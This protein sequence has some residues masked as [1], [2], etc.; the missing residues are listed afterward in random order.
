VAANLTIVDA[1]TTSVALSLFPMWLLKLSRD[2]AMIATSFVELFFAKPSA[3][4]I[5]L[6][7]QKGKKSARPRIVL[8]SAAE[9]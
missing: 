6:S 8:R 2:S 9:P 7:R 4:T 5:T 1:V 3:A